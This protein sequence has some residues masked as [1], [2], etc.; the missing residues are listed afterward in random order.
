MPWLDQLEAQNPAVAKLARDVLPTYHPSSTDLDIGVAVLH[1]NAGFLPVSQTEGAQ[2]QY[3]ST[4]E[5]LQGFIQFI[6]QDPERRDFLAS[7]LFADI[8]FGDLHAQLPFLMTDGNPSTTEDAKQRNAL[9]QRL[10]LLKTKSAYPLNHDNVKLRDTILA[11]LS[12][13]PL[14]FDSKETEHHT[15]PAWKVWRGDLTACI[16]LENAVKPAFAYS[17]GAQAHFQSY[18][19]FDNTGHWQAHGFGSVTVADSAEVYVDPGYAVNGQ[20][21][22][23]AGAF[24]PGVKA[25]PISELEFTAFT[26]IN[27]IREDRLSAN[28]QM[29]PKQRQENVDMALLF[30][31]HSIVVLSEAYAVYSEMQLP[32]QARGFLRQADQFYPGFA[33][34][35]DP[36]DYTLGE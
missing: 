3:V 18:E 16:G 34:Q 26:Y 36:N 5:Y 21:S 31:P 10:K 33:V 15:L 8:Q 9:L 7:N 13:N 23:A 35:I 19:L 25:V 28:P 12:E 11:D 32:V 1:Y 6:L 2:D 24:P 20:F 30:A 22:F 4:Q 29:S 14:K 27:V 17:M